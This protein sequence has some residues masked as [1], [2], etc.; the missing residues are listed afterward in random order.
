MNRGTYT[1]ATGMMAQQQR[2]DVVANN[3]ANVNT[4]G[5]KADRLSFRD[6]MTRNMA[7]EAGYGDPIGQ[8]YAGPGVS[9]QLTDMA[10]GG[11][12]AT[13]NPLDFMLKEKGMFAV[14]GADGATRYTRDGAFKLAAGALVTK[15][16]EAVLDEKGKPIVGLADDLKV[17]AKGRIVSGKQT[18]V[19][20]RATG[21]FVKEGANLYVSAD[22]R[23]A[24]VPVESQAL[25]T[26]NVEPVSL[27]VE[28]IALQRAYEISQKMIQS[29][30]ESTAKLDEAIG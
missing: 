25:E 23:P 14:R 19:L 29:Q 17:D 16:G 7:S 4:R 9:S 5:F 24:D 3:L 15:G 28:M 26:A 22:A 1:A 11:A 8:L 10:Q 21:T 12:E 6:M 20:G 13:G 2:L 18:F 27:M 30:D